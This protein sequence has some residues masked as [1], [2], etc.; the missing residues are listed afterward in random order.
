MLSNVVK[1]GIK[2]AEE[3]DATIVILDNTPTSGVVRTILLEA[4]DTPI[5]VGEGSDGTAETIEQMFAYPS[6]KINNALQDYTNLIDDSIGKGLALYHG[7]IKPVILEFMENVK[8]IKSRT[9]HYNAMSKFIQEMEKLPEPLLV[10]PDI[11]NASDYAGDSLPGYPRTNALSI[12]LPKFEELLLTG[13][14]DTNLTIAAMLNRASK[15]DIDLRS[16]VSGLIHDPENFNAQLQSASL[17]AKL[18]I[19]VTTYLVTVALQGKSDLQSKPM[20]EDDYT[21]VLRLLKNY[22]GI[23]ISKLLRQHELVMNNKTVVLNVKENKIGGMVIS[24]SKANFD[25]WMENNG[26]LE[27][28]LGAIITVPGK[29]MFNM[30]ELDAKMIDYT[31][32]FKKYE[33]L[34][35]ARTQRENTANNKEI[36]KRAFFMLTVDE[37][38]KEK[39]S[40]VETQLRS[41]YSEIRNRIE[42][43]NEIIDNYAMIDSVDEALAISVVCNAM[44]PLTGSFEFFNN[45]NNSKMSGNTPQGVAMLATIDQV[46]EFI[47]SQI[48]LA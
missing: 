35:L 17:Y 38:G 7:E 47:V 13:D 42:V 39:F 34:S 28:L 10:N 32:N 44:Y 11:T 21:N 24:I 23:V 20:S 4:S 27:A 6:D 41:R 37:D 25:E 36:L 8:D 29:R 16:M 43:S 33:S 15:R 48:E 3:I 30:R 1:Q 19:Y 46:A 22:Y 26:S 2:V 18:D 40:E 9:T 45:M 12:Q 5:I 31:N 14:A